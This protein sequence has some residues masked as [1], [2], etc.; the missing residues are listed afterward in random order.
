MTA[1]EQT[2]PTAEEV[3]LAEELDRP[4]DTEATPSERHV[5]V[6]RK[7]EIGRHQAMEP[8]KEKIESQLR[9]AGLA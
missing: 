8:V 3:E 7:R 1:P 6:Q 9:E 5:A 4:I 2:E